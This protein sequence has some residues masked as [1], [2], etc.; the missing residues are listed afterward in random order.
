M[1]PKCALYSWSWINCVYFTQPLLI[2]LNPSSFNFFFVS[3]DLS[4]QKL[5]PD[6]DI[7]QER[8]I[9]FPLHSSASDE[10]IAWCIQEVRMKFITL[11]ALMWT[12]NPVK[13]IF[14]LAV[15]SFLGLHAFK[16]SFFILILQYFLLTWGIMIAEFFK[17]CPSACC[18]FPNNNLLEQRKWWL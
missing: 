12:C 14:F 4:L 5:I 16:G 17:L 7:K 10:V 13:S 2:L 9:W 15:V 3:F 1:N 8:L 11:S 18:F 6:N